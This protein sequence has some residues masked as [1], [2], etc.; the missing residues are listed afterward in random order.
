MFWR[1]ID[2]KVKQSTPWHEL[3]NGP[4]PADKTV[5]LEYFSRTIFGNIWRSMRNSHWPVTMTIMG[6]LILLLM[7][8]FATG[9]FALEATLVTEQSVQFTRNHFNGSA[10]NA[11]QDDT[12]PALLNFAIRTQNLSYPRGT[13]ESTL[14]PLF[15]P[16]GVFPEDATYQANVSGLEVNM[17]CETLDIKNGSIEKAFLP[18]FSLGAPYFLVNISTP[19][20]QIKNVRVGS[21]PTGMVHTDNQTQSYGATM[22]LHVCNTDYDDSKPHHMGGPNEAA[23]NK[24]FDR[25]LDSRILFTVVNYGMPPTE[26]SEKPGIWIN[27]LTA[28]LCKPSYTINNYRVEYAQNSTITKHS[29]LEKTDASLPDFHPGDISRAVDNMFGNYAE[30]YLGMGGV[31]FTLSDAVPPFYQMIE[32]EIGG[33]KSNISL[34]DLIDPEMLKPY[35]EVLL[36]SSAVQMLH[37]NIMTG[38]SNPASD[39]LEGTATFFRERLHVKVISTGFLCAGFATMSILCVVLL[40]ILPGKPHVKTPIGSTLVVADA[41]RSSPRTLRT[42]FSSGASNVDTQLKSWDFVSHQT[43]GG[44]GVA[45]VRAAP[46]NGRPIVVADEATPDSQTRADTVQRW[47]RPASSRTWFTATVVAFAL[48]IIGILEGIQHISDQNQG[49]VGVKSMD[50]GTTV[51]AQYI[52]AAV[53]LAI[54]LMIGS[55]ELTISAVTPYA[56]LMKGNAPAS[57]TLSADYLTKSGPHIFV[58]SFLN[59]HLALSVILVTTFVASFLSIVIPGLYS[60]ITLPTTMDTTVFQLDKFDPSG[61]DISFEDHGAATMMNLLTYYNV[62]YPQWA[63]DDLAI[64]EFGGLSANSE[65]RDTSSKSSATVSLRTEATRARLR[66]EPAL[67]DTKWEAERQTMYKPSGIFNM[68]T[69]AAKSHLLWSMCS[70]PPK[71][72]LNTTSTVG[73]VTL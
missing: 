42:D 40:F 15:E 8:V 1:V 17:D 63:F 51:L 29:L 3:A 47:W 16:V 37:A 39:V 6:H 32:T 56:T 22:R 12:S 4:A 50:L 48:I 54:T 70:N 58:L 24:T 19:T 30:L 57:R 23:Y 38:M 44:D 25:T 72:L 59:R 35:A 61:S 43:R 34:K 26:T 11:T 65:P 60:H 45:I 55:I 33:P 73:A 41:L 66:C 64:P 13:T 2:L 71:T 20:C 53:A 28:L 7:V 49:F 62:E 46:S 14:F 9:L 36:K 67:E 5:L 68:V 31:D 10:Y 21:G 27:S 52:P 18:W 69:V